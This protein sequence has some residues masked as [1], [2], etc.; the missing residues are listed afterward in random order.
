[1]SQENKFKR[2]TIAG[3]FKNIDLPNGSDIAYAYFQRN[4]KV[5]GDL[6]ISGN[7]INAGLT[8]ALATKATIDYVDDVVQNLVSNDISGNIINLNLTN[9]LDS[10][11]S[12][13]YVDNAV[14]HL[15][16]N[17]LSGNIINL[18]LTNTL[19]SKATI[20][21]VD[22][23]VEYLV[24]TD[25]SGN[26]I[27]QILDDQLASK[28]SMDI[29]GNIV[30]QILDNQ[31][32]SK[33][34][35]VYVDNKVAD[36]VGSSPTTLDTLN[37]LANALG[38]DPNFATTVSNSIGLKAPINNASFTGTTTI[39]NF[40]N[41]GTF[42]SPALQTLLN[43]YALTT[44]MN[45]A[46]NGKLN[47]T[48]NN[49]TS[50]YLHFT[51][52]TAG[53]TQ[54]GTQNFGSIRVNRAGFGHAEMNFIQN[55][56]GAG[57]N[58]RAFSFMI[59][60]P[61]NTFVELA[62]I[63]KGG[64]MS[65]VGNITSP[66]ITAMSDN[67][68]LKSNTTYVDEQLLLKD[69]ITSVDNKLLLKSDITYVDTQ[70]LLKD[71]ITSVDNKLL[72]KDDITSVD[73]KLLLKSNI[74][75]VDEQ[76][77]LKDDITS[78]N[79]KLLLKDDITSVDNKLLLKSNIT[80]VD[81]QLLLK[82]N[83]TSVDNKLLLKDN[84]TSVDSKILYLQN[85]IYA[86][87]SS[88]SSANTTLTDLINTKLDTSIYNTGIVLKSDK[89]YVDTN[90]DLKANIHNG[91]HTGF[92]KIGYVGADQSVPWYNT[93]TVGS[94]TG[95]M[96]S[97]HR[98]MAFI[99]HSGR[100]NQN[101]THVA[102]SWWNYSD[103]VT[104][105]R[106]AFFRYNGEFVLNYGLSAT[107]YVIAN[108]YI[109]CPVLQ[110]TINGIV[111]SNVGVA[112]NTAQTN[113]TTLT[114]SLS[115]TNSR[116]TTL[117]SIPPVT[118]ISLG[119]DLLDNT[120]DINKPISSAQQ[121]VLNTKSPLN[122]P[123]FTGVLTA[124][125]ITT[126]IINCSDNLFFYRLVN[127]VSNPSS[128]IHL[129]SGSDILYWDNVNTPAIRWRWTALNVA[130]QIFHS[131][132]DIE[133]TGNLISPTISAIN[134]QL[135]ARAPIDNAS[136]TGT[137]TIQNFVNTGT[138]SS[139]ALQTV[140]NNYALTTT[141]NNAL[142]TKVNLNG[143]N[144]L[145]GYLHFANSS[146]GY[147]QYGTQN[148]GSIGANR[149]GFGHAEMNF[150]QNGVS[151]GVNMRAFNFMIAQPNNSLLEI[152]RI[153]TGGDIITIGNVTGNN[154]T[155]MTNNITTNT[156]NITTINTILPTKLNTNNPTFTGQMKGRS[157][158]GEVHRNTS[159][160]YTYT[161]DTLP[162]VIVD[163]GSPSSGLFG[164]ITIP[165]MPIG[166]RFTLINLRGDAKLTSGNANVKFVLSNDIANDEDVT[167]NFTDDSR[168]FVRGEYMGLLPSTLRQVW[169]TESSHSYK[170]RER[171]ERSLN[172][173]YMLDGGNGGTTNSIYHPIICSTKNFGPQA[174]DDGYILNPG[175]RAIIYS[176]QNYSGTNYSIDNTIGLNATYYASS[177]TNSMRSLKLYLDNAEVIITNIS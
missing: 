76:L 150:I 134:T 168:T 169:F 140:L 117:E 48:G 59:A 84:I 103:A 154:I 115:D 26:I 15:V 87:D 153:N 23:A 82:D 74:T 133:T 41:T 119:L 81:S 6:D 52:S 148:F 32:A 13:E 53:Y 20:E 34:S 170:R 155:A 51:N 11:A 151:N 18:N 166:T 175:F 63:N 37:E 43:T 14:K 102:F 22:N 116:V 114:N 99:N 121:I 8:N 135:F 16:S 157:Y 95:N 96:Q 39:Q 132:G 92:L 144:V 24:S 109:R 27:N 129:P 21:Y 111:N 118:K 162:S 156:N 33:A 127:G 113:I 44:T 17:D 83:I 149:A 12:I 50:G 79:N 60:Q 124:P 130:R 138:F 107:P 71:D 104:K 141:M 35:I 7:I 159:N 97:A 158:A 165:D 145:T 161:A 93:D 4:V 152:A 172:G 126:A 2:T 40:V 139:P 105:N 58:N 80:Y 42:S 73:N 29:S 62:R 56:V 10:K 65:T 164:H 98:D 167:I 171:I 5:D 108:S 85:Q 94:I 69:D 54:F 131:S 49:S 28:V 64:S 72:L 110:T 112:I 1:M 123:T 25:I 120:S 101:N 66:N 31:L 88:G 46:L 61:D 143:N 70:L 147:T 136:L 19:D 9:T 125:T 68:N 55:G 77:L 146:A 45:N 67:I 142:N 122:N 163:Q 90:L 160:F 78:V 106:I 100:L 30:N 137:T 91:N 176:G 38:N 36:L 47:T 173:G 174:V 3:Q 57:V 128:R 75:Y 177:P 89:T 86:I